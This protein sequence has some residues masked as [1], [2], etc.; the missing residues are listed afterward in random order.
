[1]LEGKMDSK[2]KEKNLNFAHFLSGIKA[3]L[4]WRGISFWNGEIQLME[5]LKVL[6]SR[7]ILY[8]L[9]DDEKMLTTLTN[10]TKDYFMTQTTWREIR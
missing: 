3:S 9:I 5:F 8:E 2:N 1:M 7:R 4:W 6:R 10:S